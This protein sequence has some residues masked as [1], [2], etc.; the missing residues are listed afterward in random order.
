MTWLY[1]VVAVVCEVGAT[2]SLKGSESVPLLYGVV[3]VGY[4]AAFVCLTL[5]LKRGLGL[6][7]AY[8]IWAAAGV[9]ITAA[10]SRF[11]FDEPLTRK[12][13]AGIGFIIT[14]VL[15]MEIGAAH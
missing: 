7:V 4:V 9:A 5:A 3:A 10:A 11:L 6:G 12:M 1:L 14:G 13:V 2:L 15:L 8:G